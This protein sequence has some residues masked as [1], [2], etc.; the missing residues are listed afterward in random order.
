MVDSIASFI[1]DSLNNTFSPEIIIL[2]ISMLPILELRG[3]MIAASL[4]GVDWRYAFIICIIGNLIPIPFILLFIEKIFEFLKK[5]KLKGM[6]KFFEDKANK[7]GS[8]ILKYKDWGL[9]LFVAIPLPGTGGW[10][11]ALAATLLRIKPGKAMWTISLG[12]VTAAVIMSIISYVIPA[13]F[14]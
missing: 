10:M 4:L 14:L 12:V 6:V 3:G 11:G 7:K 1:T 9:F 2:L 8:A 13:M 5:T